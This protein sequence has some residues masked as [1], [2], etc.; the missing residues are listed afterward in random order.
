RIQSRICDLQA[1]NEEEVLIPLNGLKQIASILEGK[2]TFDN[3]SL[4]ALLN[5]SYKEK[6]IENNFNDTI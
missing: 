5:Y 4:Q 6:P 3:N 1:P 2:L